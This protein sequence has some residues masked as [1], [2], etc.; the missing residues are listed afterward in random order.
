M[1]EFCIACNKVVNHLSTH[2]VV[3]SFISSW[4]E[5][6]RLCH[7]DCCEGTI[8]HHHMSALM[9]ESKGEILSTMCFKCK[10]ETRYITPGTFQRRAFFAMQYF[11]GEFRSTLEFH[12]TCFDQLDGGIIARE[13]IYNRNNEYTTK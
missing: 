3:L 10:K 6:E 4:N 13:L 11:N 1:N 2:C 9:K 7:V 5:R 12:I 8:G